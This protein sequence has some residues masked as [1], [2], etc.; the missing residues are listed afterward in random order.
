[1]V[2]AAWVVVA[3]GG[4][5]WAS[6]DVRGRAGPFE[7]PRGNWKPVLRHGNHCRLDR[8]RRLWNASFGLLSTIDIY[9]QQMTGGE[10]RYCWHAL[11]PTATTFVEHIAGTLLDTDARQADASG[12]ASL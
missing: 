11:L 12:L 9:I 6:T 2:V 4:A 8:R 3:G 10:G 7:I 5:S 1:M